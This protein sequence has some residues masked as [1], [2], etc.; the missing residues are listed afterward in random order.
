[1]C[2]PCVGGIFPIKWTYHFLGTAGVTYYD[3][4][5]T[6]IKEVR[7]ASYT[8]YPNNYS[9][10]LALVPQDDRILWIPDTCANIASENTYVGRIGLLD[11]NYN[12]I[13]KPKYNSFRYSLDGKFFLCGLL[14]VELDDKYGAIDRDGNEVIPLIYD[15]LLPFDEGYAFA[16][17]DGKGCMLDTKGNAYEIVGPNGE[18][19]NI[20]DCSPINSDGIFVA[21]DSISEKNFCV[22]TKLKDGKM[23]GIP[24]T[25]NL[26]RDPFDATTAEGMTNYI[27]N[28]TEE[29]TPYKD[30]ESGKWG[31]FHLVLP[32]SV[33]K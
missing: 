17:K 10:Y 25:E 28:I 9:V 26:N 19:T 12:E 24:G 20:T 7:C 6:K 27:Y 14:V 15:S 8:K 32:D 16:V 21:Y 23:V 33:K 22:S 31:Y 3:K 5:G 30:E 13:M 4:T 29:L 18:T 11:S 1:M 2:G